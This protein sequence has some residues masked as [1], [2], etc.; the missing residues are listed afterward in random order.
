MDR[1]L[2]HLRHDASNHAFTAKT[3]ATEAARDLDTAWHKA[4]NLHK[5][6]FITDP[7]VFQVLTGY[8][9]VMWRG[10]DGGA[11]A[12]AAGVGITA[13]VDTKFG[14]SVTRA[15]SLYKTEIFID[16][17]GLHS[18]NTDDDIIGVEGVGAASLGQMSVAKNGE[19]VW[20]VMTCLEIPAGGQPDVAL[21]AADEA[22]GVEDTLITALT[23]DT[24]LVQSQGDGTAWVTGDI[25]TIPV[26]PGDSQYLY[27]V[28]DGAITDGEY[29]AG[30]FL[31]EFW[32]V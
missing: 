11:L 2:H 24:E 6:V 4:A 5:V 14:S 22:T 31:I 26:F 21:W 12:A 17:D 7:G 29:S 1:R 13:G 25:I 16:M 3:Y 9:P 8:S 27:L 19:I 15:G 30:K 28:S 32:G 20:G 18:T 23:N 10:L